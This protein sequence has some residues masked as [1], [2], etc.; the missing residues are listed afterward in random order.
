MNA[1]ESAQCADWRAWDIGKPEVK[2]HYF[3]TG[4]FSGVRDSDRSV[5]RVSRIDRQIRQSEIAVA[6]GRITQAISELPKRIA[7]EVTVGTA[8]HRIVLEM[9]QLVNI[10]VES[11]RKAS[12]RIVLAAQGLSDCAPAFLARIPGFENGIG[13]RLLPVHA[14]RTTT[15]EHDYERLTGSSDG[16]D[17]VL[18]GLGQIKSGSV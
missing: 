11:D 3:I 10:L 4:N 12:C 13:V 9:R 1:L 6:K 18:F 7:V 2:L 5:Q 8:F 15:H 14:E 17:K 16:L